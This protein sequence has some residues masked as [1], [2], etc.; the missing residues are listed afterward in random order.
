M[1]RYLRENKS[2]NDDIKIFEIFLSSGLRGPSDRIR[3]FSRWFSAFI[4]LSSRLDRWNSGR[5]STSNVITATSGE[6]RESLVAGILHRLGTYGRP[7]MMDASESHGDRGDQKVPTGAKQPQALSVVSEPTLSAELFSAASACPAYSWS[8]SHR[9]GASKPTSAPPPGIGIMPRHR[10]R[11][12]SLSASD[13]NRH[14][15]STF[16]TS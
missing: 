16:E 5:R 9:R 8:I 6:L 10:V 4:R 7:P 11:L 2:S 14:I 15:F 12:S 1:R 3:L 13:K